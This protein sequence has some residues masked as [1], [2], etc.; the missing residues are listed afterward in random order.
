ME[1]ARVLEGCVIKSSFPRRVFGVDSEAVVKDSLPKSYFVE[2]CN[3]SSP[4]KVLLKVVSKGQVPK[5]GF[6]G[7]FKGSSQERVC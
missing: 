6:V 5:R 4:R 1:G 3:A 7:G 2:G